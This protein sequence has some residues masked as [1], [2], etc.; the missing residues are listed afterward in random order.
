[1]MSSS[2]GQRYIAATAS[3]GSRR[4]SPRT[5]IDWKLTACRRRPT[6][7]ARLTTTIHQ[8]TLF[9]LRQFPSFMLLQEANHESAVTFLICSVGGWLDGEGRLWVTPGW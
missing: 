1:M 4:V 8:L 6:G 3:S 2:L 7:A 9:L 5:A